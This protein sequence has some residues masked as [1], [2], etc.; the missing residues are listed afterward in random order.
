MTPERWQQIR[1]VLEEALELAPEQRSAFLQRN[2]SA[3]PSLRQEVETLLASSPDV[4]SS[5]LQSSPLPV[6]DG[7]QELPAGTV[8]GHYKVVR[9]LGRGGMGVVYQA[10]DQKLGRPVAIKLLPE[11]TRQDPSALERFWREARTASALNHPGI[12]TI[13]ELNESG[14]QLFIV[15]ELLEGQSLDKLYDRRSMPYPKLLDFGVQV[16]DAL[17]AAHRKGIL[18]RD[19]KP[20]NIFLSP[21]GQ[22]KILDFGLAK[23]EEGY[24]AASSTRDGQPNET[25]A[26]GLPHKLLTS[27]GSAIGTIAYMSPEQARGESLDARSDVFSL[28]VVLYELATGRHP[29]AGSTTAVTFDR[30]LNH[31]PASPILLNPEL[32]VEFERIVEKALEK[33]RNLRCQS[34]AELRA[35]L[36]RQKRDTGSSKLAIATNSRSRTPKRK[37]WKLI[38]PSVMAI[39]ALALV[40]YLYLQRAP[41][42][43]ERDTIVVG[44]FINSTGDATFDDTL[45]QALTSSLRQSPFLNILSDN[46]VSQTLGLMTRPKNTRLTPDI[47]QEVCQ[48]MDSKA[49]IEGSIAILGSEY[50]VGLKALNCQNGDTLAQEQ[51]TAVNKEKVLD[52]L[53]DA[54][55][56]LRRELGESLTNVKKFDVPLTQATTSSLEALKAQSLGRKT[57]HQRGTAAALPFFKHAVELDPSF[58]TGYLALGKMYNNDYQRERAKEAFTK[59][60]SLREHASEREKFDIESAYFKDVIGD[61]DETTRVFR[62]WL[63]SYA[64]DDAALGNLAIVYMR[65]GQYEQALELDRESLQQEPNDVVS[66]THVASDFM[67]MNRFSESRKTIQDA[68]DRQL[69]DETLH[70]LLY[71]LAFLAGNKQEM[72]EQVTWYE[73]HPENTYFILSYQSSVEAYFGHLRKARELNKRAIESAEHAGNREIASSWR[74]GGALREAAFGNLPEA[75]RNALAAVDDPNLGQ[76]AEE[77]GALTFA[78]VGETGHAESLLKGLAAR[79]PQGTLIQSVILP[80]ARAQI[81]LTHKNPQRSI[82]LLQT[83]GPY[84]LTSSSFNGCMYPSYVRGQAYLA[85]RRGPEAAAEFEKL[86][87]HRG[88]LSFC[89]TGVLAHLGMARAHLL[90]GDTVEAGAAYKD[91]LTLWKDADPDLPI[92]TEAKKEYAKLQ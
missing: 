89:E 64:R 28:G 30:I 58:A 27:P 45:K 19:I 79:F 35:D 24:A 5:F 81:E 8:L 60:Y 2:C 13:Y 22:A 57:L 6:R 49:W 10:E 74:M 38:V 4:R 9:R 52:A 88:L 50:I 33:D 71:G 85:A 72:A 62:E 84:D 26:E 20:G 14:G 40:A 1:G 55:G 66:Y 44:D 18:H 63:G 83:A 25:R 65:K 11:A 91:L 54:A 21:S 23:L 7:M 16:A 41:K 42:L 47:A 51:V 43:T 90:M 67:A 73:K 59:A 76:D 46:R 82:E 37:T 39:L 31:A 48:R 12:C 69:D 3:D 34:A 17:D 68:F 92:L 70:E 29:F 36:Q 15:M 75:R 56:K 80:T 87:G 86:L 53:G 78:W 77:V 61:M 32:P